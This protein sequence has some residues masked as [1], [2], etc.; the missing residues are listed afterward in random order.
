MSSQRKRPKGVTFLAVLVLWVGCV[1]TVFSPMDR[2]AGLVELGRRMAANVAHSDSRLEV[3]SDILAA[4]IYGLYLAYIVIG[5][6]LWKLHNWARQVYVA[7]CLVGGS[8]LVV[9]TPFRSM[10]WPIAVSTVAG[11]VFPVAWTLWYLWRPRVRFAFG[12]WNPAEPEPLGLSRVG[13]RWV[14]AGVLASFVIWLG[15]LALAI[16][17][18]Q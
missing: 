1:G 12:V 8:F 17:F 9:T 6:G 13:K 4:I 16:P 3:T 2:F 15:S 14:I 7:I 11:F 18:G 10:S 5:Y